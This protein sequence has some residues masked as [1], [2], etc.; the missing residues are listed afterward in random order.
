MS[1]TINK[2]RIIIFSIVNN[3]HSCHPYMFIIENYPSKIMAM[4]FWAPAPKSPAEKGIPA[5]ALG[6]S[7]QKYVN[8]HT[9]LI[10]IEC[11]IYVLKYTHVKEIFL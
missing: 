11:R 2:N 1:N 4:S 8:Q 6:T 3:P 5:K 7:L 10:S 9:F